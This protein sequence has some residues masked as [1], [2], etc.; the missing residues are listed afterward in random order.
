MCFLNLPAPVIKH[1]YEKELEKEKIYLSYAYFQAKIYHWGMSRPRWSRNHEGL[2]GLL[3]GSW[4]ADFLTRAQDHLARNGIFHSGLG[5]PM[6]ISSKTVLCRHGYRQICSRPFPPWSFYLT[7]H[8]SIS[9]WRPKL[10]WRT[11]KRCKTFEI[12]KSCNF[13]L[14]RFVENIR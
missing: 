5:S 10:T 4:S 7:H 3:P 6:L 11:G 2:P 1:S 9:R 14:I 13:K 8:R 12:S